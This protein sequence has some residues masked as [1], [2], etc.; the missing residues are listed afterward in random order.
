[1]LN[2]ERA[3]VGND[4]ERIR[5]GASPGSATFAGHGSRPDG[6]RFYSG[7]LLR[8]GGN[9]A[10]RCPVYLGVNAVPEGRGM[11]GAP[12]DRRFEQ[13]L[14]P[15]IEAAYELA[16]WLTGNGQDAE[17]VVQEAY[18]RAFQ[19]FDGWRGDNA[20]AWLLAIVR[21]TAMSWLA[22]NRPKHVTA[23]APE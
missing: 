3:N 14:L 13:V 5:Q 8:P 1:D 20:R 23:L 4:V 9:N 6:L 15:H 18:L 19:F 22:R 7:N 12:P 11:I 21:N 17:D 2:D 16:R 10:T